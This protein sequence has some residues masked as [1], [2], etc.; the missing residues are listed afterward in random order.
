MYVCYVTSFSQFD[1]RVFILHVRTSESLGVQVAFVQEFTPD[2]FPIMAVKPGWQMKLACGRTP[3]DN[4]ALSTRFGDPLMLWSTS[5]I[6]VV[7]RILLDFWSFKSIRGIFV[8]LRTSCLSSDVPAEN[9]RNQGQKTINTVP[10]PSVD[11]ERHIALHKETSW[12][13][14]CG[15]VG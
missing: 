3:S 6:N 14:P 7:A 15:S 1:F 11:C 10:T 12:S 5:I 4:M 8:C 9:Q 13:S 2:L